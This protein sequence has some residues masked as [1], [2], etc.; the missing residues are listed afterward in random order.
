MEWCKLYATFATDPKVIGLS[1]RAFRAYVEAMCYATLHETDGAYYWPQAKVLPE[2]QAAG[3]VDE[4]GTIHGWLSRQRT[5]AEVDAKRNAGRNAARIRWG[6]ATP[7]AEVEV[8]VE[9]EETR[10]IRPKKQAKTN[11]RFAEFYEAFPRHV[12]RIAAEKAF[13]NAVAAGADPEAL[14]AGAKRYR[15]DPNRDP[16]YT[17]HPATWLNQ[18][19]WMDEATVAASAPTGF[20]LPSPE[21]AWDA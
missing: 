15:D 9:V 4:G 14:I 11:P 2:L 16:K 21:E 13:A 6:N 7:N 17:A 12:G 19:R 8:E 5:R 20:A 1:D 3:L 18:G 10:T